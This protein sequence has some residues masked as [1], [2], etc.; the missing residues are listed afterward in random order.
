MF[1]SFTVVTLA[2]VLA[3]AAWSYDTPEAPGDERRVLMKTLGGSMRTVK[4]HLAG[5]S[6]AEEAIT[7]ARSMADASARIPSLFPP[8]SGMSDV[9]ASEAL[10]AIWDNWDDFVVAAQLLGERAAALET[11][12]E[13]DN[14]DSVEAAFR[15]LGAD[16]CGG[17]HTVFRHKDN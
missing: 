9:A 11:A 14:G 4:D 10:D 7:A 12:L 13:S 15:A 3:F 1:K 17:C 8:G 6:S 2:T 16:G 5:R